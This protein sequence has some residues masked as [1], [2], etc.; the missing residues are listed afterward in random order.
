MVPR[1]ITK[2]RCNHC[3]RKKIKCDYQQPACGPCLKKGLSC[4]YQRDLVFVIHDTGTAVPEPRRAPVRSDTVQGTGTRVRK[5][6][7]PTSPEGATQNVA[8]LYS[9]FLSLY[10]PHQE[11]YTSKW[12]PMVPNTSHQPRVVELAI[13]AL[14]TMMMGQRTKN[15][16]TKVAARRYYGRALLDLRSMIDR[17]RPKS[18]WIQY[19]L[20]TMLLQIFES[21]SLSGVNGFVSHAKGIAMFIQQAGPEAFQDNPLHLTL[22]SGRASLIARSIFEEVPTF[23]ASSKWKTIPWQK[24]PKDDY[25]HLLDIFVQVPTLVYARKQLANG[26]SVG[27]MKT[28]NPALLLRTCRYVNT[29]LDDWYG[30]LTTRLGPLHRVIG[31][32]EAQPKP[33]YTVPEFVVPNF[34]NGQK[35]FA[36]WIAKL[37]TFESAIRTLELE[38]ASD[39]DKSPWLDEEYRKCTISIADSCCILSLHFFKTFS[40]VLGM[41]F[42]MM[43]LRCA[44]VCYGI[45][46]MKERQSWCLRRIGD[47]SNRNF[48]L[49]A[50]MDDSKD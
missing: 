39:A 38:S 48:G 10:L 24:I 28:D 26:H 27:S 12:L 41:Q 30:D 4:T 23:L 13:R 20:A 19:L 32:I 25:H 1:P 7:V 40:T 44:A 35:L 18:E 8:D 5:V 33:P 36:F 34:S 47:V 16:D 46:D 17:P 11:Q 45:F 15:E 22:L 29:A 21:I 37:V 43:P 42:V 49:W 50:D 3:R 6:T 31:G 9:K 2:P 14:S